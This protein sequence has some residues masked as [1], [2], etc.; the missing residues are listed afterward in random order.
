MV[1]TLL[2]PF[3]TINNKF[4]V[5]KTNILGKTR[6]IIE[7]KE[8]EWMDISLVWRT[9]FIILAVMFLLKEAKNKSLVRITISQAIVLIA[10]VI[11]LIHP[12]TSGNAWITFAT[13][14]LIIMVL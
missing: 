14:Y 13:S 1:I 8:A 12:L 11:L 5:T 4:P 2:Y 6:P 10:T 7:I 3:H 9:G